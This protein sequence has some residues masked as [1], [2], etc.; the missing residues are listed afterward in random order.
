MGPSECRDRTSG[1]CQLHPSGVGSTVG[2]RVSQNRAELEEQPM[3]RSRIVLLAVSAAIVILLAGGSVALR[4]G[5]ADGAYGE[6]IL[7]SELLSL[8]SD[9]Y[10]DPVDSDTLL[11]DA[12]Q[13]ML[14]S[15]DANGAYLSP[16]EVREWKKGRVGAAAD[17]GLSVVKTTGSFQ[18]VFV[19]PDSPAA[20]AG[21][22]PGDQIRKIDGRAARG[23]SLEQARRLIRG[24]PGTSVHLEVL[25]PDRSWSHEDLDLARVKRDFPAYDLEVRHGTAVLT[26]FDL[27]RV[28]PSRVAG[29]LDALESR[30]VERLMLDLR[31]VS[32]G[33]PRDALALLEL[34]ASA[35]VLVLKNRDGSPVETIQGKPDRVAWSGSLAAL[36]NGATAGGAEAIAQFVRSDLDAEV[37]GE[38]TYGLGSEPRLFELEGG[39]G[40]LV[41][42]SLWTVKSGETWNDTGVEPDH[43]V[44]GQGDAADAFEDQLRRALES[45]S[46]AGV[47]AVREAA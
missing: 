12:Y 22:T 43:T 18:V 47:Q 8:I 3:K 30:H 31:N 11:R 23:L 27:G 35:P 38:V 36:V 14:S 1:G 40:L 39:S 45:F 13:G 24:E 46:A 37:Y 7:F 44:H 16:D 33:D 41:S 6:V 29:E 17:P 21:M 15:L 42:T 32:D 19:A 20:D 25:H 10:V 26:V 5:A 28:T 2:S 34:F 9:N 4:V